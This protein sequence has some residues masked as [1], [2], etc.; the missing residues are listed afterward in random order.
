MEITSQIFCIF[1]FDFEFDIKFHWA[2][3]KAL[4]ME[5]QS[6]FSD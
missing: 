3:K 5:N 6:L 2:I 1:R 4:V